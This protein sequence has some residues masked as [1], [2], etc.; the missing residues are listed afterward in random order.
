MSI[1]RS[2]VA[3]VYSILATLMATNVGARPLT[4]KEMAS[5][6]GGLLFGIC[7]P[8]GNG[9]PNGNPG[10]CSGAGNVTYCN[11]SA[12]GNSCNTPNNAKNC[13]NSGYNNCPAGSTTYQCILG[14]PSNG[15]PGP[16]GCGGQ[17]EQCLP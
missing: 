9:C 15:V 17:F 5:T 16:G 3:V 4:D 11:G 7:L 10:T 1:R 8:N 12:G 13:G 6:R 2:A 14:V